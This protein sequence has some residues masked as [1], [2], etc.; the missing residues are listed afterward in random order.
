MDKGVAIF[1]QVSKVPVTLSL[2]VVVLSKASEVSTLPGDL[3]ELYERALWTVIKNRFDNEGLQPVGSQWVDVGV[4]ISAKGR[5]IDV[6]PGFAEMLHSR[7]T[8]EGDLIV[9]THEEKTKYLAKL[10]PHLA[11]DSFVKAESGRCFRLGGEVLVAYNMLKK[12]GC[13]NHVRLIDGEEAQRVFKTAATEKALDKEELEMWDKLAHEH[14][15]VPLVKTL[16]L[17]EEGEFRASQRILSLGVPRVSLC[18][19]LLCRALPYRVLLCRAL[20]CSVVPHSHSALPCPVCHA[21]ARKV[22]SLWSSRFAIP[23][24]LLAEFKHHS[25]Q[26]KLF[27]DSLIEGSKQA[28]KFW[29]EQQGGN[30]QLSERLSLKFYRNA[31]R[32]GRGHLGKVYSERERSWQPPEYINDKDHDSAVCVESL[33]NMIPNA[34]SLETFAP[35]VNLTQ[36]LLT[37]ITGL[38]NTEGNG[39]EFLDLSKVGYKLPKVAS[40]ETTTD[41]TIQDAAEQASKRIVVTRS[42]ENERITYKLRR[43]PFNGRVCYEEEDEA[44]REGPKFAP[45]EDRMIWSNGKG[46]W[47]MGSRNSMVYGQ[48]K[49]KDVAISEAAVPVLVK[50]PTGIEVKAHDTTPAVGA[51]VEATEEK[52]ADG[53]LFRGTIM[54]VGADDENKEKVYVQHDNGVEEKWLEKQA[55]IVFV[56]ASEND[57]VKERYPPTPELYAEQ[58]VK[59]FKAPHCRLKQVRLDGRKLPAPGNDVHEDH[60]NPSNAKSNECTARDVMMAALNGSDATGSKASVEDLTIYSCTLPI[61]KVRSKDKSL[62]SWDGKMFGAPFDLRDMPLVK[63]LIE[64][65][66]KVLSIDLSQ[67]KVPDDLPTLKH[68]HDM[69]ALL[70]KRSPIDVSIVKLPTHPL[71]PYS[72]A[73]NAGF[74]LLELGKAGCDSKWFKEGGVTAKELYED[75]GFKDIKHFTRAGYEVTDVKNMKIFE[76]TV[77]VKAY[78]IATVKQMVELGYSL[79][80]I[81]EG[82]LSAKECKEYAD[83]NAQHKAVFT[84]AKLKEVGYNCNELKDAGFKPKELR[85]VGYNVKDLVDVEFTAPELKGAF[86]IETLRGAGFT[87]RELKDASFTLKELKEASFELKEL[88]SIGFPAKDFKGADH[89]AKQLKELEFTVKQLREGGFLVKELQGHFNA[90]ELKEA[91]YPAKDLRNAKMTAMQLWEAGFNAKALTDAGYKPEQLVMFDLD[92]LIDAGFELKDLKKAGKSAAELKKTGRYEAKLLK[93]AG[94]KDEDLEKAGWQK[95]WIGYWTDPDKP[96]SFHKSLSFGSTARPAATRS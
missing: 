5:L 2:Y 24:P 72:T 1:D 65:H 71:F 83:S 63:T 30:S 90:K 3:F 25:L 86:D 56:P 34:L 87:A 9:L 70:K 80:N 61:G 74:S 36:Q 88:K 50:W 45:E 4:K 37:D 92:D 7:A 23:A 82:G 31:F 81:K 77:V 39:L 91:G 94:F 84:L 73:K 69:H 20:L 68:I 6:E 89:T 53:D 52:G 54:A 32:I 35:T 26:E 48:P 93:D 46:Q 13:H 75:A 79:Q 16:S 21:F 43:E 95:D 59:A 19:A 12:V 66:G 33:E 76:D 51:K 8:K 62:E 64:E 67:T 27:V 14:L 29:P 78:E 44:K 18:C 85:E 96:G 22:P 15:G 42:S 57:F 11:T 41:G 58:L 28:E 47:Y 40:S 17:G 60:H 10:R 55:L 49:P 38:V